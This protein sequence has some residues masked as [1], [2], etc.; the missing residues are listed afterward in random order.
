LSLN[1]LRHHEFEK[2]GRCAVQSFWMREAKRDDAG[3]VDGKE[4]VHE[5]FVFVDKKFNDLN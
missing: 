2:R 4:D 1:I 3:T 5:I